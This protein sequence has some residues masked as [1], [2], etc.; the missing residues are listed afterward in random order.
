MTF[1]DYLKC[2]LFNLTVEIFYNYN[3]ISDIVKL[4]REKGI[5]ISSFI[6]KLHEYVINTDNKLSYIYNSFLK[7]TKEL[8]ENREDLEKIF[9]GECY[10]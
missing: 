6:I 5:P 8:W 7:E 9:K 3:T 4:V 1:I 2:R 10:L